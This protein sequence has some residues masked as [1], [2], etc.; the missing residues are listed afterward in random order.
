MAFWAVLGNIAKAAKAAK[1]AGTAA[2]VAQV[3]KTA[4]TVAKAASVAKTAGTVAKAASTAANIAKVGGEFA[5]AATGMG[6]AAQTSSLALGKSS[7]GKALANAQYYAGKLGG[8]VKSLNSFNNG[9]TSTSDVMSLFQSKGAPEVKQTEVKF[10]STA[11]SGGGVA[12]RNMEQ[13]QRAVG[14]ATES[15]QSSVSGTG[16]PNKNMGILSL[17][18]SKENVGMKM[19]EQSDT[20]PLNMPSN[21]SFQGQAAPLASAATSP[22]QNGIDE[23]TR[24]RLIQELTQNYSYA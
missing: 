12:M 1:A 23:E 17:I 2:K 10:N 16:A 14:Q 22:M 3:A 24:L 5:K 19:G 8:T 13:A 15:P 4:S 20:A 6:Q 9:G 18:G 11:P 21:F 7:F